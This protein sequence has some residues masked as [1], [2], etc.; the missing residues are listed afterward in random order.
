M[1]DIADQTENDELLGK[2]SSPTWIGLYRNKTQDFTWV[3]GNSATYQ[4]FSPTPSNGQ[5]LSIECVN[6]NTDGTWRSVT[7]CNL[8][9]TAACEYAK[10]YFPFILIGPVMVIC[11]CIVLLLSVEVCK[12]HR[13]TLIRAKGFID[14]EEIPNVDDEQD[15]KK[16]VSGIANPAFIGTSK[17][18]WKLFSSNKTAPEA[19]LHAKR[20]PLYGGSPSKDEDQSSKSGSPSKASLNNQD[21]PN[22][23]TYSKSQEQLELLLSPKN[24]R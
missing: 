5:Q 20:M 17:S 15:V 11:G 4:K 10:F 9:Y 22:A 24:L 7:N 6:M 23:Q 13:A 8:H 1:V 18:S 14:E 19:I 3:S 16:D 2:I 21:D 12:R